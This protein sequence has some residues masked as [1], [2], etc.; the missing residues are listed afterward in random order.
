MTTATNEWA[1]PAH[2]GAYLDRGPE[3]PPHRFEGEAVLLALLASGGGVRRRVLD[4]GT[5]DGRLLAVVLA[6]HSEVESAAAVDGSPTML[7]AA[8]R[9]FAGGPVPVQVVEH[10][11]DRPLPAHRLGRFD[12]VISSFAI[13]HCPDDRKRELY[14][15]V[16]AM[17]EPGGWFCNLE[18]VASPTAAVHAAFFEAIGMDP[19]DE[20][21]SNKLVDVSTQLDWLREA[22]LT[23]VD[24]YWKWREEALVAGVKPA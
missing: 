12:A 10:N 2:A 7:A 14:A 5:G 20:D 22:G 13:H 6:A 4:L 16:A 11:L 1:T 8:R 9:R 21:P 18:H 23:D 19:A 3:W 24:C 17:L 15:E